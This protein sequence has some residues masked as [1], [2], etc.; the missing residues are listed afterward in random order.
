MEVQIP[1]ETA[2]IW[3]GVHYDPEFDVYEIEF[4]GV[5][6]FVQVFEDRGYATVVSFK[7]FSVDALTE[8]CDYFHV[9]AAY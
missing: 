1:L 9:V 5:S 4:G 3:L 2:R 8:C 7:A 6:L